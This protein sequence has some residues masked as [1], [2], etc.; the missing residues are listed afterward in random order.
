M[1]FP[2]TV[3]ILEDRTYCM[4]MALQTAPYSTMV[5]Q[6]GG[7]CIPQP[8][9]QLLIGLIGRGVMQAGQKLAALI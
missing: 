2:T 9:S 8:P 4:Y 5:G 7:E 6:C 3:P 1:I